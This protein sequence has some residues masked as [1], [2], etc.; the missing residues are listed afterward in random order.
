MVMI[1]LHVDFVHW[2]GLATLFTQLYCCKM[3]T[4]TEVVLQQKLHVSKIDYFKAITVNN[5]LYKLNV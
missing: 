4:L 3:V 5:V 2:F 1:S